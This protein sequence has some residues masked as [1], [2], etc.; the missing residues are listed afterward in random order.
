[1]SFTD[2]LVPGGHRA[3]SVVGDAAILHALVRTESAWVLA[4]A[5]A[6][7]ADA[8]SAV[9]IAS[10]I[11][12]CLHDDLPEIAEGSEGGGNPVI[13]LVK[14]L[15][16]KV[17]EAS[18]NGD[19]SGTALVHRGL[20]SQDVLDT[21]LML[22]IRDS[23]G[24]THAALCQA[25]DDLS[26]MAEMH[27][28]TPM[29]ARTL[30]QHALPTTFGARVGRWLDAVAAAVWATDPGLLWLPVSGGGAA[31]TNAAVLDLMNLHDDESLNM[32]APDRLGLMWAQ[33]LG[34]NGPAVEQV[35]HTRRRPMIDAVQPLA[36]AAT[37]CGKIAG[38]IV[39]S[40]RDEIAEL[41]EPIAAGR[42][43]SSSMP[44]KRNPSMSILI[45]RS[46]VVAARSMGAL[47]ESEA[48]AV[49]ERSELAWH[50]EWEPV[51][52][53]A[54]HGIVA[55]TMLSDLVSDLEVHADAMNANLCLDGSDAPE[56]R[57]I[58]NSADQARTAARRW[59]H[60][61]ENQ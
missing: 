9:R 10:V 51:R 49:E 22:V 43:G 13:G 21:A 18:P 28:E 15:K 59:K 36:Q 37:A 32:P 29:A 27:A 7:F 17:A 40:S 46:A 61:K 31:G 6:G 20:T 41:A 30:G 3:E 8:P 14:A 2:L 45:R 50:L 26:A 58:G 57:N 4:Q 47:L 5:D 25:A 33:R 38:D 54:Q 11:E 34:L 1:M 42:G 39:I 60:A 56:K 35:W 24:K 48:L 19:D 53:V 23:L 55:S 12:S 16:S 52:S 44:H